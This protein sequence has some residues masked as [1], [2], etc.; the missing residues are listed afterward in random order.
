MWQLAFL[1]GDDALGSSSLYVQLVPDAGK[2]LKALNN[3]SRIAKLLRAK[4][5]EDGVELGLALVVGEGG[6][7]LRHIEAAHGHIIEDEVANTVHNSEATLGTICNDSRVLSNKLSKVA[8]LGTSDTVEVKLG[9]GELVFGHGGLESPPAL[10]AVGD[11]GG[12]VLLVPGNSLGEALT[13]KGSGEYVKLH[14]L[15]QGRDGEGGGAASSVLDDRVTRGKADEFRVEETLGGKKAGSVGGELGLLGID[16]VAVGGVHHDLVGPTGTLEGSNPD[17]ITSL[18]VGVSG[19][20]ANNGSNSL[21]ATDVLLSFHGSRA[22]DTTISLT[23]CTTVN[24]SGIGTVQGGTGDLDDGIAGSGLDLLGSQL[25]HLGDG[26][27]TSVE[28]TLGCHGS[29]H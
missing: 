29:R 9:A 19:S 27:A 6:K 23:E 8:K 13:L 28:P 18:E 20:G 15:T 21:A 17:G 2:A 24:H 25:Q 12:A 22:G 4:N 16:L 3:L 11:N 14:L 26:S 1:Q 7:V 10:A 5:C